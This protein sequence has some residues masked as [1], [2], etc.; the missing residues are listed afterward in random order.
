MDNEWDLSRRDGRTPIRLIR[1]KGTRQLLTPTMRGLQIE[2]W[3]HQ[4]DNETRF[5]NFRVMHI[6][7]QLNNKCG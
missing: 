4:I 7:A 2:H 6:A 5:E 3:R 1:V